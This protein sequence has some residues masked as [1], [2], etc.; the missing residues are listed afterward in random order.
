MIIYKTMYLNIYFNFI[1]FYIIIC[2]NNVFKNRNI[3]YII[4]IIYLI[5][6]LIYFIY[7][8]FIYYI[9]YNI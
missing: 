8:S 1:L 3:F 9:L 6:S 7:I 2:I 4:Y 5:Y